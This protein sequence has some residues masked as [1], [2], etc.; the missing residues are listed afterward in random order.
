M[1]KLPKGQQELLDRYREFRRTLERRDLTP[2][3][4]QQLAAE[5]EAL[6][7]EAKALGRCAVCGKPIT[8]P[9]RGQRRRTCSGRCRQRKYKAG[10]K[11]R[12]CALS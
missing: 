1:T 4:Y 12:A 11:K 8:Q 5:R 6:V 3:Q 10:L 7:A 2:A 9:K